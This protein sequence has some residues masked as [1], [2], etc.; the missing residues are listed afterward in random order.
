MGKG[1]GLLKKAPRP[2][3]PAR[4]VR[5]ASPGQM[6]VIEI[7]PAYRA[8]GLNGIR[9]PEARFGGHDRTT[10][11]F[12]GVHAAIAQGKMTVQQA[13]DLSTIARQPAWKAKLEEGRIQ[14]LYRRRTARYLGLIA[15]V[16]AA[17]AGV[18]SAT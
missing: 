11:P 2:P 3:R 1:R 15:G 16:A 10:D 18:E 17:V 7:V 6:E 14:Q 8:K 12:G 5:R 13:R 4:V 9:V